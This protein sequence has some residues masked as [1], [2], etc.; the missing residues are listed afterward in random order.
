MCSKLQ[1]GLGVF[2]VPVVMRGLVAGR[3][4]LF[5]PAG[6]SVNTPEEGR[7]HAESNPKQLLSSGIAAELTIRSIYALLKVCSE[8]IHPPVS[9]CTP[10]RPQQEICSE[11]EQYMHALARKP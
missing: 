1:A 10:E 7:A 3:Q 5:S 9:R 11:Y 8:A 4:Q 2:V 6:N